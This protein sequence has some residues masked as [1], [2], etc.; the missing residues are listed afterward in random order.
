M[1]ATGKIYIVEYTGLFS[2]A[3]GESLMAGKANAAPM[4]RLLSPNTQIIEGYRLVS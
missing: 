3:G 4:Q 2:S 1:P